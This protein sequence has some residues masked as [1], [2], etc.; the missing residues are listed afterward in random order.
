MASYAE[1]PQDEELNLVVSVSGGSIKFS[2]D[3]GKNLPAAYGHLLDLVGRLLINDP[4]V[5]FAL[6]NLGKERENKGG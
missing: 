3:F 6:E 1:I 4:E 5:I 2:I